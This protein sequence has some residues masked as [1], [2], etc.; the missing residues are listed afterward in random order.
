MNDRLTTEDLNELVRRYPDVFEQWVQQHHRDMGDP[1]PRDP[2][3]ASQSDRD[4]DR[5]RRNTPGIVIYD[6]P[7]L[8]DLSSGPQS[9]LVGDNQQEICRVKHT[10]CKDL[11]ATVRVFPPNE[12][13]FPLPQGGNVGPGGTLG[14]SD[15]SNPFNVPTNTVPGLPAT[16]AQM[17]EVI[18]YLQVAH[19][20]TSIEIPFNMPLGQFIR[21]QHMGS[22]M[23]V[24]ARLTSR[25]TQKLGG[26]TLFSWLVPPTGS[27]FDR[28]VA[29]DNPPAVSK[30]IS[31]NLR[32]LMLQG[33]C[34]KSFIAPVPA[35][36]I[37][38]G[39]TD[40]GLA[41]GA[42]HLCP[43][44]RGAQTVLLKCDGSNANLTGTDPGI[45]HAF[46][47]ICQ[48]PGFAGPP[49]RQLLNQPANTT[50][51]LSSDCVAIAVVNIDATGAGNTPRWELI[52]DLGL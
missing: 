4:R 5:S 44:P 16:L 19:Q 37:F 10:T 41:A 36:R 24:A 38:Y 49:F 27:N 48:S 30:Q 18:G 51:R 39:W 3:G 21:L 6:E 35:T 14:I 50:V 31:D 15:A 11:A 2:F 29:F 17:T 46:F 23:R 32:P 34:G 26:G 47:E 45:T 8:E 43:V 42:R 13:S 40:G 25:Y 9:I 20:N 12:G 1:S 33:F 28:N 52:Y 22:A 7:P